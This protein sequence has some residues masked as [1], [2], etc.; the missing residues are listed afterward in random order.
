MNWCN[1]ITEDWEW[2]EVKMRDKI[3]IKKKKKEEKEGEEEERREERRE[4]REGEWDEYVDVGVVEEK[5][6][7][8]RDGGEEI[9]E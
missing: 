3:K 5:E 4:E 2:K 7:K 8:G 6:G 1:Q 9:K